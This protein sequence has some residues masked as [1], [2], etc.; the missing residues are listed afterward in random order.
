MAFAP[1]AP[2]RYE[3]HSAGAG[4]HEEVSRKKSN[5]REV[6]AKEKRDCNGIGG[7]DGTQSG[8]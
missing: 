8:G 3:E 5:F 7:E 2:R 6:F 1:N 4:S